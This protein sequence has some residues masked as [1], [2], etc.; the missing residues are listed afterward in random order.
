MNRNLNYGDIFDYKEYFEPEYYGDLE[1][2]LNEYIPDSST[3]SEDLIIT[4]AVYK[5][6]NEYIDYRRTN[7][8]QSPEE[9][10]RKGTGD[11]EDQTVLLNSML[12]ASGLKAAYMVAFD[13]VRKTGHMF[14]LVGF[15][16]DHDNTA[17]QLRGCYLDSF[18]QLAPI[19]SSCSYNDL[20]WF[21]AD[22][23]KGSSS[24]YVGDPS[25]LGKY[26]DE[27]GTVVNFEICSSAESEYNPEEVSEWWAKKDTE[28]L[29][30]L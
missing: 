17:Q 24:A 20:N 18:D 23:T 28:S 16:G 27:S 22:P 9:T 12:K 26:F 14:P 15:S 3:Y 21:Y 10:E 29:D 7:T 30:P 11:C 13:G 5:Y 1:P 4:I 25:G 6:V 19:I 8:V 2:V